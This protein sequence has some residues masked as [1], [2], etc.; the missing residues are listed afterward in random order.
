MPFKNLKYNPPN[1]KRVNLCIP[2]IDYDGTVVTHYAPGVN[3]WYPDS[4]AD[5]NHWYSGTHGRFVIR[6]MIFESTEFS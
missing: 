5:K 4:C 1:R 3:D 6:T 2:N